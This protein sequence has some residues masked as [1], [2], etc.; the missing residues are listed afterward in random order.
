MGSWSSSNL[1]LKIDLNVLNYF[2]YL[3]FTERTLMCG[4]GENSFVHLKMLVSNYIDNLVSS[5]WYIEMFQTQEEPQVLK[6][7]T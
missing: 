4:R 7:P 6:V 1:H 5:C 2:V 3:R